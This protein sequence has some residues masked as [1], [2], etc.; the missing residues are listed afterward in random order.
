M[1]RY[2]R[3]GLAE[4]GDGKTLTRVEFLR[5]HARTLMWATLVAGAVVFIFPFL[6]M[7][8]LS[9]KPEGQAITFPPSFFPRSFDLSP[10]VN[11]W[12]QIGLARL[13]LNTLLF[14]GSVTVLS[15]T[16]DSLA[17][18]A[19]ARLRFPGKE[20][21]FWIVLVTLMVPVAVLIVPLFFEVYKFHWLN[22]YQGLIVP[23]AANGYGIFLLRQFFS[24]LP[25][26]LDDAARVDGAGEF[27]IYRKII[28]RLSGPAIAAL[29]VFTFAFNWNN[30][31]W[32]LIITTTSNMRTLPS[33][34][35][36]F[37]GEHEVIY[38]LMSAAAVLAMAPLV[39]LFF[40]LQRYFV[41]GIAL[42][43]L[44]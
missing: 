44:R 9:V 13:Y 39:V 30:F 4:D 6:W 12:S 11:V 14:A 8:S 33:G 32:P 27:F 18:Y 19:F 42:S 29:A 15:V 3:S 31:L 35:V 24:T 37:T 43:G 34:L 25:F 26:E 28:V 23:L 10:Y 7:L 16:L 22:T 2:L 1:S 5:R 40:F 20:L 38:N 41:R 21:L 17:A 36:L